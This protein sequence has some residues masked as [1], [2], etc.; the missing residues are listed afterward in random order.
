MRFT[1]QI[2]DPF[3]P[4]VSAGQRVLNSERFLRVYF[5][6]TTDEASAE[7]LDLGPGADVGGVD[8]LLAPLQTRRVRGNVIDAE[9]GKA[10]EAIRGYV[11]SVFTS[12]ATSGG[13]DIVDPATGTFDVQIVRGPVIL[14]I[15]APNKTGAIAIPAGDAD[16]NGVRIVIGSGFELPGRIT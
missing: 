8:I 11:S 6:N 2:D 14:S 3:R 1:S 16:M 13:S 15:A 5:P 12:P 4:L 7:P 10:P 9:T